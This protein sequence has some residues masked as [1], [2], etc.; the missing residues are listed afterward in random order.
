MVFYVTGVGFLMTLLMNKFRVLGTIGY[1][2]QVRHVVAYEA[3][4]VLFVVKS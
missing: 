3:Y 4:G 2:C 1:H